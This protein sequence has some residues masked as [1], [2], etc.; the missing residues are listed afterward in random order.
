MHPV[1]IKLVSVPLPKFSEKTASWPK[2][3]LNSGNWLL[4]H[5]QNDFN[6]AVVCHA[7]DGYRVLNVLFCI[8]CHQ[9]KIERFFR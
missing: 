5:G 7:D 2:I 8:K 3:S 6:M 4:S 1:G 9:I